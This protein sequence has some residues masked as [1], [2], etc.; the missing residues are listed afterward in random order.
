MGKWELAPVVAHERKFTLYNTIWARVPISKR[1]HNNMKKN[2]APTSFLSMSKKNYN[3]AG[4][5]TG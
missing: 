1:E 2:A 3:L 5:S 4:N